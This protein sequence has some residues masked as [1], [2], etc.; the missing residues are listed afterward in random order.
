MSE[1]RVSGVLEA[2]RA[3]VA[4][5]GKQGTN[6]TNLAEVRM[7]REAAKGPGKITGDNPLAYDVSVKQCLEM[8]LKDADRIGAVKCYVTM[9]CD[10]G[11]TWST[12]NYRSCLTRIEEIAFRQLGVTEAINRWTGGP[13]E[14]GEVP[15]EGGA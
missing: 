5:E 13:G 11:D 3:S 8:A 14:E 15:N 4:A 7:K 12:N 1:E 2:L 10:D 9:I 6:V